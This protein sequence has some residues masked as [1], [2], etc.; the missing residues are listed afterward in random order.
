VPFG[1]QIAGGAMGFQLLQLAFGG[2]AT[3]RAVWPAGTLEANQSYRFEVRAG[4]G[5]HQHPPCAS[6]PCNN[7]PNVQTHRLLTVEVF[8]RDDE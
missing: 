2:V 4:H 7:P 3:A 6:Q 8:T 5:D 1:Y